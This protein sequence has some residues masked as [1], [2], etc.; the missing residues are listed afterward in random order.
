MGF[1]SKK[2]IFD[3]TREDADPHSF[4]INGKTITCPHCSNVQFVQKQILLN[5]PG[6][7]FFSLD[8]AN[9]TAFTLTCTKCSQILW[10]L[11]APDVIK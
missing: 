1:F 7:T 10:F 11:Q 9:K 8:W 2:H 5:T 3:S 4:Q 6:M